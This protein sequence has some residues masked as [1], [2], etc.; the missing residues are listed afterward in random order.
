MKVLDFV[1]R[2]MG[3]ELRLDGL[4]RSTLSLKGREKASITSAIQSL[5]A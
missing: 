4:E 3:Q 2:W 1:G 5:W